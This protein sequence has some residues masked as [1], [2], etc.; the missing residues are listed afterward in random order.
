LLWGIWFEADEWYL[1]VLAKQSLDGISKRHKIRHRWY[2]KT[3]QAQNIQLEIKSKSG[4]LT[5]KNVFQTKSIN[6]SPI[7]S[8][9]Q[10][11]LLKFSSIIPH[12]IITSLQ[13]TLLVTY[14]RQYYQSTSRIRLTIDTD[15]MYSKIITQKK[16]HQLKPHTHTS[17]I[18]ELKYH[19]NKELQARS[20]ISNLPFSLTRH[21]KYLKGLLSDNSFSTT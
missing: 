11:K 4:H 13:P 2:G 15:I 7:T 1:L 5:N 18:I 20:L 14:Q 19:P 8:I 6:H 21:S 10:F 9:N 17:T 16:L 12:S 3:N